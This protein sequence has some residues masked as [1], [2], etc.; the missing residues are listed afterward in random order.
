MADEPTP[1]W[2]INQSDVEAYLGVTLTPA[3]VAQFNVLRPILQKQIDN[4]CNR[5]WNFEN[6]VVETFDAFTDSTPRRLKNTFFPKYKVSQTPADENH[7]QAGGIISIIRGETNGHNGSPLDLTYVYS[8]GTHI[9]VWTWFASFDLFNPMGFKSVKITYNSDDSKQVP[10]D[11]KGAFIMWL[12]RMINTAPDAGKELT[13]TQAGTVQAY[14]AQ[15]KTP[16]IPDF[17]KMVLDQYR[18]PAMDY[19]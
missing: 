17:V 6:P 15:D 19:L 10:E 5:S 18:I 11:V 3:G 8:Y 4:Y 12:A 2:Y 16:G 1:F 7:P 14:Y 13:R 9:K